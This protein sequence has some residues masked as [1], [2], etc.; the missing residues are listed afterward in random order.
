MKRRSFFKSFAA[1]IAAVAL[2]P[3]LAFNKKLALPVTG[4]DPRTDGI[5]NQIR[6]CHVDGTPVGLNLQNLLDDLWKLQR[7]RGKQK[8]IEMWVHED[9]LPHVK[10][11]FASLK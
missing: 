6:N 2:A 4:F 9:D 11:Y 10:K 8:H 3:E 7:K 5:Y 1:V